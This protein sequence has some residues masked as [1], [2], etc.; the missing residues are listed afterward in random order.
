MLAAAFQAFE[1]VFSQEFR[2]VLWKSIGL[3]IALFIA[4]LISLEVALSMLTAVP[5]PWLET[6]LA[7][8]TG[9]G[10]FAS[11]FFLIAPVTAVFAGLF[12]DEIADVVEKRHYPADPPGKPL[13]T[14]KAVFIA[15]QFGALVL[16]VNLL[17]LPTLFFGIG[18]I[19]MTVANAYFL[20]REYFSMIAM[21][22]MPV[23]EANRLRKASMGKIFAAG[24]IPAGLSMVPVLNI[25]VPLF[26]TSY[27]VHI[28]KRITIEAE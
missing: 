22:H 27:F 3:T 28:F 13:S 6:V 10:V 8:A 19:L 24:F 23:R 5:W 17:L 16:I 26:S 9:L 4:I 15:I 20:G 7:V 1:D 18:A 2:R 21:R 11:L 12:L 14:G 25:L